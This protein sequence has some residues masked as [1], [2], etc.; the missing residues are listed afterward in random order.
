MNLQDFWSRDEVPDVGDICFA[1]GRVIEFLT[2]ECAHKYDYDERVVTDFGDVGYEIQI[3][4]EW[5]NEAGMVAYRGQGAMGNVG[6]LALAS[7]DRSIAWTMVL[8]FSNPFVRF[9]SFDSEKIVV[10]SEIDYELSVPILNPER[11][12]CKSRN[13]WGY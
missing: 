2:N 6:V 3:L 10:V 1:T 13:R 12:V 11:M 4:E 8:D 7:K 9:E 5:V